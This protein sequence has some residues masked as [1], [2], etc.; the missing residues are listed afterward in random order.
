M[1]NTTLGIIVIA[2]II[3]AGYL[4]SSS[5]TLSSVNTNTI[6][7]NVINNNGMIQKVVLSEKDLNY[8]PQEIRVKAN[9]PVS[10]SLDNKVKGCLRSFTIR[11][12]GISKYLKAVTD[13]LEFTPTKTGTFAFSCSMGMGFGKLIVE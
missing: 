7:G 13:T 5:D 2:V 9:Q 4:I 1:K 6:T 3:L 12:L 8:Y 11:D 10:L